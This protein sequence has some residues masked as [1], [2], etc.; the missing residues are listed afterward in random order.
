V[1]GRR[2]IRVGEVISNNTDKTVV[3]AIKREFTHPLYGKRVR[4]RKKVKAH[5]EANLCNIGDTVQLV[6][7]RPLSKEKHWKVARILAKREK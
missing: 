3:V 6:E 5:D 2:K 7:T 1:R 4:R